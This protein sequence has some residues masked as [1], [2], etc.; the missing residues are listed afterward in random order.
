MIAAHKQDPFKVVILKLTGVVQ[1]HI[2][3]DTESTF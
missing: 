1:Q 2:Q 3:G